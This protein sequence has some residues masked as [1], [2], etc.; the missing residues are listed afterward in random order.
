[1]QQAHA[2]LIIF[3]RYSACPKNKL[4]GPYSAF[5]LL[6]LFNNEQNEENTSPLLSKAFMTTLNCLK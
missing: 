2:G 1:M 6:L 4:I 5:L 3:E